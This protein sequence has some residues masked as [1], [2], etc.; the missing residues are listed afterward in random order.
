MYFPIFLCHTSMHCWKDSS[1]M[2][3]SFVIRALLM[4]SMPSKMAPLMTPWSL[5]K[6]KK[7]PGDAQYTQSHYFTDIP[8]SSLIIYQT[9]YF[10]MSSWLVIIWTVNRHLPHTTHFTHATLISV[11]LVEG[12]PFLES[13]FMSSCSFFEPLVPLKNTCM[14]WLLSL[15]TC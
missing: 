1:W 6:R 4:T 5:E 11:L 2:P 8:K 12:L 14:T 10:F 13:S 7:Y 9:L 15:Y 3:L